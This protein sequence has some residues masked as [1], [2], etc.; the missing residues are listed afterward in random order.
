MNT[1]R[2]EFKKLTDDRER[3]QWLLDNKDAEYTVFLDNDDTFVAFGST[4]DINFDDV[5][6][7][8]DYIG[9]AD[10]VE[11]LMNVVGINAECV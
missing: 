4:D 5:L 1:A 3:W 2:D 6:Y 11:I 7:F 8:D 9:W 10:G